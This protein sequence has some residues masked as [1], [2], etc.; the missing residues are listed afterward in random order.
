MLNSSG[1]RAVGALE[2]HLDGR[3]VERLE[4][5]QHLGGRL[6]LGR[7]E[8]RVAHDIGQVFA[9]RPR[10]GAVGSGVPGVDVAL[11]RY[12]LAVLEGPTR[13]DLYRPHCGVVRRSDRL[14]LHKG[15]LAL[16]VE[17]GER[18]EQGVL[19][20]VG[21]PLVLAGHEAGRFELGYREGPAPCRAGVGRRRGQRRAPHG[22]GQNGYPEGGRHTY[23][24]FHC[25]SDPGSRPIDDV[26]NGLDLTY[27]VH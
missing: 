16:G 11:R 8:G 22:N 10:I 13:L 17:L 2:V 6:A 19:L 21:G 5:R 23:K 1:E 14:G 26:P 25:C 20:V 18:R 7:V 9:V 3:G 24:P 4:A 27:L 12:R 15:Q